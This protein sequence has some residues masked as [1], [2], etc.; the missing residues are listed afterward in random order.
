MDLQ[1][2]REQINQCD[3]ELSKAFIRRMETALEIAK[4]KQQNGLPV[5]D[6][7]RERAVISKV[8]SG[9]DETMAINVKLLYNTIFDLSRTWQQRYLAKET[10]L[11]NRIQY[12]IESTARVFPSRA[13]VACQGVEG[14]YSQQACDK[15]FA[16]PSLMYCKRFEG[17]FQAIQSGLC[18][19]GVLPI[20]NSSYGSVNEVYDLMHK[21]RFSIVRSVRLK[22]D[23]RLLARPGVKLADVKEIVSH[24]QAIG[25]C[26]VYLKSLKDVK[27]TVFGNTAEAAQYVA[28]SDRTDL[29]AI[30]SPACAALY[31]LNVLSDAVSDS[32][33]NYTRFI[34]IAKE[35]QIYPGANRMSLMLN[36]RHT[37]GALYAMIAKFAALG[38]NLTKIESRPIAGTDFEFMF[39][40]DLD[41]SVYAPEALQL[42]CELD[43]GP[44]PF[45]YLGSYSEI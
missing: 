15:L 3:E 23:H 26:G 13:V 43:A 40:F 8:T 10:E 21:Y 24:E 36:V 25:Q 42:L 35:L 4:Y 28:A 16:L 17:V 41:A 39:Y 12:A 14:A 9:C 27:T 18:E 38:L 11:T 2:L 30:S 7:E 37:P 45:T 34:C 32:D 29:A 44:E 20:E 1:T 6:P 33:S 5:L 19:Y 22:I 31:G